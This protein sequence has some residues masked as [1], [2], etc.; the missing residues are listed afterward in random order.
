M[1]ESKRADLV[2]KNK[3]IGNTA[4]KMIERIDQ[5]VT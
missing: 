4:G 3:K 2:S 1:K 5:Q